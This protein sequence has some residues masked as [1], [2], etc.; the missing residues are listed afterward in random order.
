[1]GL[2]VILAQSAQ[3]AYDTCSVAPAQSISGALVL[4]SVLLEQSVL[5]ELGTVYNDRCVG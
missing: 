4:H 3:A 1:M 5:A 2:P